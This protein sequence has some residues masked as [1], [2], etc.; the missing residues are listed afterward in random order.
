MHI[1]LLLRGLLQLLDRRAVL[2][3][4]QRDVQTRPPHGEFATRGVDG[5][6]DHLLHAKGL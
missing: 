3:S 6:H 1:L 2:Q 5:R 4:A